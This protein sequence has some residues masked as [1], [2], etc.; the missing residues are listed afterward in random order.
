[1]R[2]DHHHSSTPKHADAKSQEYAGSKAVK[3]RMERVY[4][5]HEV[6]KARFQG[7]ITF[8]ERAAT[9]SLRRR[10]ESTSLL[11][12]AFALRAGKLEI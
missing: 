2:S 7:L 1:M 10:F 4:K 5:T 11:G 6:K 9:R 3:A 12:G 8:I